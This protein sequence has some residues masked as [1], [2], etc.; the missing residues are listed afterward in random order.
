[1]IVTLRKSCVKLGANL[2]TYMRILSNFLSIALNAIVALHIGKSFVKHMRDFNYEK[3]S[4]GIIM[5]V[6]VLVLL[7]S[8]W[9]GLLVLVVA[10]AIGLL[11]P[12]AGCRRI[13]AMGCLII[14]VLFWYL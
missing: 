10:V 6:S 13:H 4:L 7:V 14:P 12:L 3:I 8:G 9:L 5:L 1:M 2:L 11:A